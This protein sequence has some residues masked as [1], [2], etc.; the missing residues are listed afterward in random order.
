M[1][2][3]EL[4][5]ALE[6]AEG[7]SRELDRAIAEAAGHRIERFIVPGD[8]PVL[9]GGLE[10][11]TNEDGQRGSIPHFT[12]SRDAMLP[13]ESKALRTE[14][15]VYDDRCRAAVLSNSPYGFYEG[16]ARTEP[17]A[18]RAAA[19]RAMAAQGGG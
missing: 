16:A 15:V 2:I 6:A 5:A 4:I 12:A 9:Q 14:V 10:F 7:P 3:D 19:L 8:H 13:I 17:L 1:T 18:R 11:A